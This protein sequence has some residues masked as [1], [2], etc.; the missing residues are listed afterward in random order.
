MS[1]LLVVLGITAVLFVNY[2]IG[3]CN[4]QPIKRF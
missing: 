2:L 1:I 3:L 4:K